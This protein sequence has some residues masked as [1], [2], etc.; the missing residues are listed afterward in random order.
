MKILVAIAMLA[1]VVGLPTATLAA[2]SEADCK[3]WFDKLDA[4]KNGHLDGNE[5]A[6]FF[7]AMEKAGRTS[8]EA[9]TNVDGKIDENEF[10]PVCESGDFKDVAK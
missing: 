3:A 8:G 10:L 9:D 2:T 7:A 4:N 6:P 5:A 1:F